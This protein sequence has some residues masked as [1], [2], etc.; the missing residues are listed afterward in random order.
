MAH[1]PGPLTIVAANQGNND[2]AIVHRGDYIIGEAY[3][4]AGK[5]IHL[6]AEAN[7]RLW[8]ASPDLL[9][10]LENLRKAMLANVDLRRYH[11]CEGLWLAAKE[12]IDKAHGKVP[13]PCDTGPGIPEPS[14]ADQL[15]DLIRRI[16]R[17]EVAS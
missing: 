16:V 4:Q 13:E 2:F 6:D 7:A 11:E 5:A 9:R 10:A 15:T 17:E 3:E 1:T 14:P 12:A 8:A